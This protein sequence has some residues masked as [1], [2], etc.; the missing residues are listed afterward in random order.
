MKAAPNIKHWPRFAKKINLPDNICDNVC[1]EY[2]GTLNNKGYGMFGIGGNQY[3]AHRISNY[4]ATGV[5]KDDPVLHSCDNPKCVNPAHLRYGTKKENT[6]DAKVK[7]RLKGLRRY[8]STN[9][10]AKITQEQADEIRKLRGQMTQKEAAI[11]YNVST[12]LIQRVWSGRS[13]LMLP[14]ISLTAAE[15]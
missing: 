13:W 12:N 9:P 6:A 11:L 8:G 1:W 2:L 5:W 10:Q 15:E 7:G 14:P 3:L 4:W